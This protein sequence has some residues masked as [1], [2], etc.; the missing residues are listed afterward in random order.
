LWYPIENH[1][2]GVGLTLVDD[3][4]AERDLMKA[5]ESIA[6]RVDTWQRSHRAVA[7]PFAVV[8]KAGD[9]RLNQY[10]VGL[11]WYGFVA[12]YPLLLVIIT[13]FGFVGEASLG[14]SIVSTLHQF[15]V[16]G[17]QFNPAHSNELHGSVIG[18]VV[19]LIGLVYGAQ[20]VTQTAQQAL[21]EVWNVPRVDAPGFVPR[22][23]RSLIGLVIIGA[24]FLISAFLAAV[25]NAS[26]HPLYLRALVLGALV[27]ANILMYLAAFRALT[28]SVIGTR[29]LLP[30]AILGGVGFTFFI[31]LGSGLIEHQVRN[32]SATY[33]QFGIVIGLVGFLFL[34]AKISL[35]G[36]ELNP[37]LSRHLWPRGMRSGEPSNADNAVLAAISQAQSQQED[38]A[39]GVDFGEA[40]VQNGAEGAR[41]M[42]PK[43]QRA[44]V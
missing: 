2:M 16:V 40:P 35:Y 36:A 24:S 11:G 42:T 26:G 19:G 31:T 21:T 30:G 13:I 43:G 3:N 8:K 23:V 9:D 37:V 27:G 18:L 41:G 14:H 38:Q 4:R 17:S 6:K 15:P 44:I 25:A 20:G 33:G 12:I 5:I 22:L 32:S 7:L 28:P 34:V 1:P 29:P 10:V 39:I